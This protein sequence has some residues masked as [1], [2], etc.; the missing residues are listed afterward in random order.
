MF[1]ALDDQIAKRDGIINQLDEINQHI[2]YIEKR[3][4]DS[5]QLSTFFKRQADAD[6]KDMKSNLENELK[7]E[8]KKAYDN[9]RQYGIQ[10]KRSNENGHNDQSQYKVA[11]G[12][13]QR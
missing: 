3:G 11:R 7:N 1:V 8:L 12:K 10:K 5:A 6:A 13:E 9:I 2:S 4:V